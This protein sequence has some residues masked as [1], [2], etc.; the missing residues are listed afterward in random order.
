M[1]VWRILDPLV[2]A[3]GRYSMLQTVSVQSN[4]SFSKYYYLRN[5][6]SDLKIMLANHLKYPKALEYNSHGYALYH[7]QQ[8]SSIKLGTAGYFDDEGDWHTVLNLLDPSDLKIPRL[9]VA[10]DEVQRMPP[11]AWGTVT[12]EGVSFSSTG[13]DGKFRSTQNLI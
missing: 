10:D 12:G 7:P 4:I 3:L 9:D 13:L 2:V 6:F 11:E 1:R 5:Q 8:S